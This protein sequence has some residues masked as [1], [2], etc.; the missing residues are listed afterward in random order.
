MVPF[1]PASEKYRKRRGKAS[2]RAGVVGER[3]CGT[4]VCMYLRMHGAELRKQCECMYA[5][6]DE[7]RRVSSGLNWPRYAFQTS[8]L[9]SS[10]DTKLQ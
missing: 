10:K 5:P 6:D 8:A 3:I 7:Q 2:D 4:G 9:C 1:I